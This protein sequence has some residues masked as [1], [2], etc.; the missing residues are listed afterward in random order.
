MQDIMKA[1]IF[2]FVTTIAVVVLSLLVIAVLVYVIL[3][4]RDVKNISTRVKEEGRLLSDD[5]AQLRVNVRTEGAKFKHFSTFF[6]SILRRMGAANSHRR[7]RKNK[8]EG[9]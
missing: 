5:L 7:G 4:L 8:E 9:E 6:R 3:I 1:D 2:F